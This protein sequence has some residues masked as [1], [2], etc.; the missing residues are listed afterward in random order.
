M[1]SRE[2]TLGTAK[3]QYIWLGSA[4][5]EWLL[6]KLEGIGRYGG[7]SFLSVH[8]R[9]GAGMLQTPVLVDRLWRG[10]Q[11]ES[12]ERS[13]AQSHL[14]VPRRAVV[15]DAVVQKLAAS[16]LRFAHHSIGFELL[17]RGQI[18]AR[19]PD[20]AIASCNVVATTPALP[21]I[22]RE[23]AHLDEVSSLY[24]STYLIQWAIQDG[25][26]H[27]LRV[28]GL[29]AYSELTGTLQ[30]LAQHIP[31]ISVVVW[32][33]SAA[34]DAL[35]T[36]A[37][38]V[39]GLNLDLYNDEGFPWQVY[40]DRKERAVANIARA[41]SAGA[42]GA[43]PLAKICAAHKWHSAFCC[44]LNRGPETRGV[45]GF[46]RPA[47]GGFPDAYLDYVWLL[48]KKTEKYLAEV[49]YFADLTRARAHIAKTSPLV[50]QATEARER[51]HDINDS[52]LSLQG[53]FKE[54][55]DP[56]KALNPREFR[57]KAERGQVIVQGMKRT[58]LKSFDSFQRAKDKRRKNEMS[59]FLMKLEGGFRF[60]AERESVHYDA[61]YLSAPAYCSIQT[62]YVERAI[63]NLVTNG[64]Y[65]AKQRVG[66]RQPFVRLRLE[67]ERDHVRIVILDSGPGVQVHPIERIFQEG[68]TTKPGG[69]GVGLAIA[70]SVV[71][72]HLGSIEVR[73]TAQYGAEFVVRLPKSSTR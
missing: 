30:R 41:A 60:L 15:A 12:G 54:I 19:V 5:E 42:D 38:S 49:E 69:L 56:R 52:M 66:V 57:R 8:Y 9:D 70:K 68:E 44:P 3:H 45:I 31:D 13:S 32:S 50:A 55:A 34:Y 37:S 61:K 58:L 46:F 26:T 59:E 47:Y 29:D 14:L 24:Y 39:P 67:D 36:E 22:R 40:L 18:A 11:P 1:A 63:E 33:H 48:R 16:G 51:L 21:E 64:V 72:E 27:V 7:C 53:I 4:V 10:P 62:F 20:A 71:E 6:P 43:S 28:P 23:L 65:F 2:P 35:L 17:R 25:V 73:N